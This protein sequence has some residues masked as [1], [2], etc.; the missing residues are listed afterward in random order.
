MHARKTRSVGHGALFSL[1]VLEIRQSLKIGT[2]MG[3]V[4]RP[5]KALPTERLCFVFASEGLH[6]IEACLLPFE[7]N[8]AGPFFIDGIDS[9]P[10]L[11]GTARLQ[12]SPGN[13][14]GNSWHGLCRFALLC[15]ERIH[16]ALGICDFL[17]GQLDRALTPARGDLVGIEW[18][19]GTPA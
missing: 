12:K 11:L 6:Y 14:G 1:E 10:G 7:R 2:Q 5:L 8:P 15:N 17:Q 3:A 18:T 19:A 4:E 13:F 16:V 9:A